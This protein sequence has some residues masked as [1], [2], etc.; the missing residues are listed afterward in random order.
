MPKIYPH[1]H[2]CLEELSREH[3]EILEKL[4]QLEETTEKSVI[5]K[6]KIK[7]FL[8]FTE[9]FA[10]PHHQKEEEVLFPAL[11][12]KGI[13]R[14][15]GPIGVMLHDHETKREKVKDLKKSLKD[16]N[17]EKIKE[18]SQA[19][20]SLLR[21]HINKEDNI[22]YPLA[23]QVLTEEELVGLG[24]KCEEIKKVN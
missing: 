8:D 21:D 11:E 19:I 15:G 3:K 17:E 20:I 9:T 12:E 16:N 18:A 23:R 4:D 13:P 7:E 22:L 14:E 2:N 10:E 24:H 6:S 5:E 1:Q